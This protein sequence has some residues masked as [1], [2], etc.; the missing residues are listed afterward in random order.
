MALRRQLTVL[1]VAVA[2]VMA[3]AGACGTN[4]DAS[5]DQGSGTPT[6]IEA[7]TTATEPDPTI[8]TTTSPVTTTTLAPLAPWLEAVPPAL[9]A[10]VARAGFEAL[11]A[12]RALCVEYVIDPPWV[13]L[14]RSFL[15]QTLIMLG[16]TVASSGCDA[17]LVVTLTGRATP[18]SYSGGLECYFNRAVEGTIEL[19][20]GGRPSGSWPIDER[21]DWAPAM[22]TEP[23]CPTEYDTDV[24]FWM[25]GAW[26]MLLQVWG[27]P[28]LAASYLTGSYDSAQQ[29]HPDGTWSLTVEPRLASTDEL[30][31]YLTDPTVLQMTAAVYGSDPLG[32]AQIRYLHSII[33]RLAE[34]GV[35]APAGLEVLVP[36]LLRSMT[37]DAM[38]YSDEAVDAGWDTLAWIT[39]VPDRDPDAIWAWYEPHSA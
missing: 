22:T 7:P 27:Y 31:A 17:T 33:R 11:D 37:D 35:A 1:S 14:D 10:I 34:L 12:S 29:L 38:A 5:P 2:A 19:S 20:I 21:S 8:A 16:Y 36:H 26:P 24:S 30:T 6:T 23:N 9:P 13:E 4:G 28:G 32:T 3:V 25:R 15:A 39:S 18:V